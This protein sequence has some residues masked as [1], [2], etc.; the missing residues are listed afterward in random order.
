MTPILLCYC[1]DYKTQLLLVTCCL[2][3]SITYSSKFLKLE[4]IPTFCFLNRF[5]FL[6]FSGS[7]MLKLPSI[8]TKRKSQRANANDEKFKSFFRFWLGTRGRGAGALLGILDGET[9]P[10]DYWLL[11]GGHGIRGPD[12]KKQKKQMPSFT[13]SL[14]PPT[15]HQWPGTFEQ[16]HSDAPS[17]S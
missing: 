12:K 7:H 13:L 3:V 4:C 15:Y 6:S 8:L 2:F 9:S 1:S 5:L 10:G 17:H 14:P 11:E 16:T